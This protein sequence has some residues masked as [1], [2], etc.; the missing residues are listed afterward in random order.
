MA[1]PLQSRQ[2]QIGMGKAHPPLWSS[3]RP[4]FPQ[5]IN[6]NY[7]SEHGHTFLEDAYISRITGRAKHDM[8]DLFLHYGVD[9]NPS[10][11]QLIQL[12]QATLGH[13]HDLVEFYLRTKQIQM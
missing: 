3:R 2:R 10:S 4:D 5:R 7:R 9:V 6:A 13:E 8:V 1:T 11:G 12:V